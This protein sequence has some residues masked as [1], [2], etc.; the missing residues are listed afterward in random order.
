VQLARERLGLRGDE[1][2]LRARLLQRRQQ[3]CRRVSR[4]RQPNG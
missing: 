4:H 3:R 1:A 2:M